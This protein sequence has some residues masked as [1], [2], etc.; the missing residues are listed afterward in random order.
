MHRIRLSHSESVVYDIIKQRGGSVRESQLI[1][2]YSK[3]DLKDPLFTITNSL[4][5]KGVLKQEHYGTGEHRRYT[6]NP[7]S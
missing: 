4:T 1:S 7:S 3:E 5:A 6:L 2:D